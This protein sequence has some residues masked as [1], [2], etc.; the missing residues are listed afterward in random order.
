MNKLDVFQALAEKRGWKLTQTGTT[1]V[2]AW[3]TIEKKMRL[4]FNFDHLEQH[5]NH[6]YEQEKTGS[7]NG[8]TL[9]EADRIWF[10]SYI[11]KKGYRNGC[12]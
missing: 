4:F 6:R 1:S 7:V 2:A 8:L 3:D 5:L 12:R 9:E 11:A 10:K